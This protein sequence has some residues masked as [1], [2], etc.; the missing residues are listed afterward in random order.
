L[1]NGPLYHRKYDDFCVWSVGAVFDLD[2]YVIEK[3]RFPEGPDVAPDHFGAVGI[4]WARRNPGLH[5]FGLYASVAHEINALDDVLRPG[6]LLSLLS[7][8]GLGRE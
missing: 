3:L 7:R 2:A 8:E 4:A 1:D 6:V 5:C